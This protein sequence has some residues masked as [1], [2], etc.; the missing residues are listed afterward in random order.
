MLA[1]VTGTSRGLGLCIASSLLKAGYQVIGVSRNIS[2]ISDR[3]YSHVQGD[4][5]DEST[6]ENLI[7]TMDS[8]SIHCLVLNAGVLSP[9]S[10]VVELDLKEMKRAFDVNYFS[11]V[12]LVQRLL[13][14]MTSNAIILAI[15]SGASTF[16]YDGWLSYCSSK[17]ALEMFIKVLAGELAHQN[18]GI[19]C[20]IIWPG[21]LNT[22][23]QNEIRLQ[24]GKGNM[25]EQQVEQFIGYHKEGKLIEAEKVG[26]M[27]TDFI[28]KR[29]IEFHGLVVD[30]YKHETV[31]KFTSLRV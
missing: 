13:P 5:C 6:I 14:F 19:F 2:S 20:S 1:V 24:Q 16:P 11:N 3:N 12:R 22:E 31:E 30:F 15:G 26:Q 25:D 29:P 27:I 28:I 4:L 18:K 10:P 9:I 21:I 17:A 8:K 7:S 23:M